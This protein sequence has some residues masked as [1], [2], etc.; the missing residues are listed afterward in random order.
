MGLKWRHNTRV[1]NVATAADEAAAAQNT[2]KPTDGFLPLLGLGLTPAEMT[3]NSESV[4]DYGLS[5][6]LGE[7]KFSCH[8]PT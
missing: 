1:L 2:K 3:K 7:E 5:T 6:P 8:V 4:T